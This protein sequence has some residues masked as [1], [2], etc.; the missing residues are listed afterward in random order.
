MALIIAVIVLE[1]VKAVCAVLGVVIPGVILTLIGLLILVAV[2][3]YLLR[4]FGVNL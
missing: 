4:L 1:V 2:V 3:I